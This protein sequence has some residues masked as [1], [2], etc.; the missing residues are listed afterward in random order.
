MPTF[1]ESALIIHQH[2]NNLCLAHFVMNCTDAYV[3]CVQTTSTVLL[4]NKGNT[5]YEDRYSGSSIKQ[6]QRT[7]YKVQTYNK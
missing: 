3:R 6:T 7:E 1:A 2:I 4:T 5:L